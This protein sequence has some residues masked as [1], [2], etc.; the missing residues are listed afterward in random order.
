MPV[1]ERVSYAGICGECGW[2]SGEYRLKHGAEV[3]LGEH[4][5][6]NHTLGGAAGEWDWR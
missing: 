6:I 5:K 4:I 1:I 3:A 2:D